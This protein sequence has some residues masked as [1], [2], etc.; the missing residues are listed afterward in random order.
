[1]SIGIVSTTLHVSPQEGFPLN[2]EY[3]QGRDTLRAAIGIGIVLIV[4]A[5][6]GVPIVA[7]IGLSVWAFLGVRQAIQAITLLMLIKILNSA[8]YGVAGI[9]ALWMWLALFVIAT[10]IYFYA[11]LSQQLRHPVLPGLLIFSTFVLFQSVYFS[12]YPQVSE[13]KLL[14]F[15]YIALAILLAFRLTSRLSID[16][17]PW[18]V[19][20]WIAVTVL[21]I[22]TLLV[23]EIGYF[24]DGLGFQGILIHPQIFG[25]FLA[26]GLAWLIGRTMLQ[27]QKTPKALFIIMALVFVFIFL[28]RA[29][30]SVIAIL[31]AFIVILLSAQNNPSWQKALIRRFVS[32]LVILLFLVISL[33]LFY[34]SISAL[35]TEFAMKNT[36]AKDI[37]FAFQG[38]R[39]FL[40]ADSW[41]SFVNNPLF[42]IGFGV[43]LT[44]DFIPVLEPLTGL[45]L[46]ATTEKALLPAVILEE[47]G[48]FGAVFFMPLLFLLIRN[49][50]SHRELAIP[51]MFLTCLMLN[52]GEMVFFSIGGMGLYIWLLIGWATSS[53]E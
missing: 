22:P 42:G 17:T 49:G 9:S 26:P 44:N 25:L 29:R 45:P 34:T 23:K 11:F 31:A 40:I 4:L 19:G 20:M 5:I 36:D 2:K 21:S 33:S 53:L 14:S 7:L 39:G 16:W 35:I 8:V 41:K 24:R 13:F 50:L 1:M 30:T 10:R 28:T 43:S 18:F 38:S 27:S 48:I 51:L 15:F 37:G 46:S 52:I 3:L 12:V 47:T 6:P 32:P